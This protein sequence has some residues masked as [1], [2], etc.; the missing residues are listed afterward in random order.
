METGERHA[1]QHMQMHNHPRAGRMQ[2][3]CKMHSETRQETSS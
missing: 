3:N 1:F 2:R